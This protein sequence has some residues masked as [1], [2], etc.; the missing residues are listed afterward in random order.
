M[1]KW[2]PP[3]V[4]VLEVRRSSPAQGEFFAQKL[5]SWLGTMQS[6]DQC[7]QQLDVNS[8][9]LG[10]WQQWKCLNLTTLN[11]ILK[12]KLIHTN[13]TCKNVPMWKETGIWI[14]KKEHPWR[15]ANIK[16]HMSYN[17]SVLKN[18]FLGTLAS[19][20][21]YPIN[22]LN[23]YFNRPF[24]DNITKIRWLLPTV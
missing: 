6:Q 1:V 10:Q 11:L 4:A 13:K 16:K 15:D 17:W 7:Q 9:T 19:S 2:S 22:W 5:L 12:W 20:F 3:L 24:V 21:S 23:K 18:I 14:R 8:G